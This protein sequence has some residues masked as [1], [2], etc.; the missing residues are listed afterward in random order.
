MKLSKSQIASF[1][2]ALLEF[3][4][5]SK[6]EKPWQ[7]DQNPYKIWLFEVIMQQTRMAQGIPYYEKIIDAFPTVEDLAQASEDS[8]FSLWKGLGYYS[9]A[10]NLQFTAKYIAKELK[11]VFPN[12]YDDLLKLKG[13]GEY[14][15]AAIASFAY[16]E[17]IAVLDGNVHRILSRIF[18][19]NK[20]I[21]S[22]SDKRFF[23]DIANQ[24]LIK[25]G[26]AK[27]N[28]AMMDM[29]SQVCT[30][31]KPSCEN[32]SFQNQCKAF[33]LNKIVDLPP[34]KQRIE[35]KE[36]H[37]FCLFIKYKGEIYLKKRV[38]NDIWKGLYQ[39]IVQE[40]ENLD[41]DFWRDQKLDISKVV[42]SEVQIQL[43]SHQRIKMR[44]GIK[45]ISNTTLDKVCF[46]SLE[47]MESI[48]LPRIVGKW[49]EKN[50]KLR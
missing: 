44:F 9:R 27:F 41:L 19:I 32:C 40:G 47:E 30:P 24:L 12:K 10:K 45:E 48:A 22:S 16:G 37:F 17:N 7:K 8:L 46:F 3:Q 33:Q 28:Q 2:S 23:Q 4:N 15:A 35:L 11:G 21:Q 14:T 50:L 5:N 25:N 38:E 36:R 1:Q 20:T 31:Q 26:S 43:L 6:V 29:G 49:W 34:K 18:G 39:G 13:V 42:W